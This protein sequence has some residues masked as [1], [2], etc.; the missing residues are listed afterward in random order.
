LIELKKDCNQKTLIGEFVG[1]QD[2]Q[3]LVG[4]EHETII[5]YT[6][7]DNNSP[8][9]CM[10]PEESGALFSKY[11]FR[12]VK[13]I[14]KGLFDNMDDL[15][16]CLL[17]IYT[18]VGSESI[19]IAEEGSVVYLV[20][21]GDEERVLSLGKMKTMEYWIYWKLWE[22]LK[23]WNIKDNKDLIEAGKEDEVYEKVEKAI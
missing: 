5:F 2:Y 18:D 22:K 20:N 23:L 10:L 3:H 11:S 9:T 6:L 7:V 15:K 21:R 13:T 8:N 16:K 1:N 14:S 17:T 19:G 12:C 4:Y